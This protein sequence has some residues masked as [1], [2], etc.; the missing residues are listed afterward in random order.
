MLSLFPNLFTFGLIAP[1]FI[2]L[3]VGIFFILQGTR[4]Q[5]EEAF[6]WN[7]LWNDKKIGSVTLSSILAKLQ[8]V[9]GVLLAIGLFTQAAAIVALVF[10]WA[11]WFL[12]RR[13][14]MLTFQETWFTVLISAIS[15]A[16]LFLGA[17]FFAFDLPL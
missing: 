2:R 5:K 15:I 4:R 10:V 3:A 6:Q 8:I 12:K 9:V 13:T 1:F 7:A 11:E 17:G 16:L 14:A